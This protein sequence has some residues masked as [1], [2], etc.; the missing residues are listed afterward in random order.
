MKK[1]IG[2]IFCILF[3]ILISPI[4]FIKCDFKTRLFI[5]NNYSPLINA[6]ILLAMLVISCLNYLMMKALQQK[7]EGYKETTILLQKKIVAATLASSKHITDTKRSKDV[8]NSYHEIL[9]H[10]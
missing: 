9:G 1:W 7:D 10:L 8:V 3:G 2:Y 4:L 5:A 6:G